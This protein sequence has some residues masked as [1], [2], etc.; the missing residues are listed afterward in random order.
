MAFD[1]IAAGTTTIERILDMADRIVP[2]HFPELV[3]HD[4]RFTWEEA[5]E[6]PLM[7]R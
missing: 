4:G 5:A 2:G 3:K 7:V 6:F 1:T